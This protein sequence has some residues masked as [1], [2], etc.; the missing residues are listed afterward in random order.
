MKPREPRRKVMIDARLRQDCGWSD[1]RILNLSSRGLMARTP[2][3]PP[4]GAYVEFCRGAHRIVARVVW[5]R[6]GEFGAAAQDPIAVEAMA[7]G[8]DSAPPQA[9]NLNGDRRRARRAEGAAERGERSRRW[10]RRMEFLA[11]GALAAAAAIV[12]FD[13]V[14]TTLSKPLALVGAK[15]GAKS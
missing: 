11:I 9:A 12:A 3:A 5:A 15:L 6:D 10:S 14:A 7:R 13:T 2:R 8:R 4:R 1:A